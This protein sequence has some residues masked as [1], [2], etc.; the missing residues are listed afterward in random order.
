[1][2]KINMKNNRIIRD[3]FNK[4]IEKE[5]AQAINSKLWIFMIVVKGLIM[6]KDERI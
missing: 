6:I 2:V 3:S 5:I 4:G 1:M